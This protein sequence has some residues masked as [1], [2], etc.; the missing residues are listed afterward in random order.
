MAHGCTRGMLIQL[1]E[2]SGSDVLV[3]SLVH[4]WDSLLPFCATTSARA[5]SGFPGPHIGP[6]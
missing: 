1:Y 3:A 5:T 6:L 2:R 4:S